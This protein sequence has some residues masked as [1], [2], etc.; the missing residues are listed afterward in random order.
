MLIVHSCNLVAVLAQKENL[1][2]NDFLFSA[3]ESIEAI[4]GH[5]KN[6]SFENIAKPLS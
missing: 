5:R 4:M 2:T 1:I 6:E 3:M